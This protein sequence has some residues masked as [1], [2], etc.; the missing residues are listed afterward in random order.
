MVVE[1]EKRPHALIMGDPLS[2]CWSQFFP[3]LHLTPSGYKVLRAL[4]TEERTIL[5]PLE[6]PDMGADEVFYTNYP[7]WKNMPDEIRLDDKE[8][9][10]DWQFDANNQHLIMQEAVYRS[11]GRDLYRALLYK[12]SLV[13]PFARQGC[14]AAQVG[15]RQITS[16][17]TIPQHGCCLFTYLQQDGLDPNGIYWQI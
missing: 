3:V 6:F 12:K 11:L 8:A 9:M 1:R 7:S 17:A 16:L 13:C 14:R 15:C 10:E 2:A 4:Q 5:M